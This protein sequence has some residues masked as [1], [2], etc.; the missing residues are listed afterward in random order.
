MFRR[1]QS[2][3]LDILV[4]SIVA[5]RNANLARHAPSLYTHQH[6]TTV[7]VHHAIQSP[8]RGEAQ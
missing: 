1:W 6:A 8:S 5:P 4:E 7:I 3:I 2:S